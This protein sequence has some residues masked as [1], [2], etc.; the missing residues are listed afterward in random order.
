MRAALE[1]GVELTGHVSRF[2][3]D[4]GLSRA[5]L[6]FVF[7]RMTLE[8]FRDRFPAAAPP[9][10]LLAGLLDGTNRADIEDPLGRGPEFFADTFARI[11]QAVGELVRIVRSSC[12]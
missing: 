1:R 10:F 5:G 2:L 11:E 8:D 9:V 7:D 4:R 12:T 6:V 3:D